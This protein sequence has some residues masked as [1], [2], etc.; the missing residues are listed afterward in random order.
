[1]AR[2]NRT[3]GV[4][5]LAVLLMGGCKVNVAV[6]Q[7]PYTPKLAV[8]G[9]IEPGSAPRVYLTT[10]VP[11]FTPT[12]TPSS[13][14]VPDASVS[15]LGPDSLDDLV[16]DSTWS[17]FWCRWEPFYQGA[18]TVRENAD[19]RL[20]ISHRGEAFTATAR[21]DLPAVRI[22][23]V[24]YVATFV[25]I[26]G[27]HEGV[28]VD[29]MDTPGRPDQY[30]FEMVRTLDD[31][32]TTVDDRE[33]A[34]TCISEGQQIRQSDVGRFVYFDD[35]LDGAPVRFVIE[36]AHINFKG[37][38]ATV[39]IQSL[40]ANVADY[41]DRLDRQREANVNPFIEPVFLDSQIPGMIGVFGAIRRSPAVHFI[42]PEDSA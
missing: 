22:D 30:R 18:I 14:F 31:R 12:Q 3:S 23:T 27:G 32:H 36:P 25:D 24:S 33:Y 1:M 15:I 6:D 2:I 35:R 5:V 4:F 21:T 20:N 7:Q 10:T 11:F 13:L 40:D 41:Y 16:V 37:D 26:Y 28:V 9:L 34:S 42:F 17:D 8:E 19:Y 38:E 39:Y 29:F